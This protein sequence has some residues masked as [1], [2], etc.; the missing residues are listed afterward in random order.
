MTR[1][2]L[3]APAR[4]VASYAADTG[5]AAVISAA[6]KERSIT[7]LVARRVGIVSAARRVICSSSGS[8][9]GSSADAYR[10]STGYGSTAIHATSIHASAGNATTIDATASNATVINPTASDAATSSICEGVS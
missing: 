3:A 5:S 9:D 8:S 10:H 7:A 1:C 4:S 2:T 6:V